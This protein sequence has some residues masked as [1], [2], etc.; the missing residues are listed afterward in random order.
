M[1]CCDLDR[2]IGGL[3]VF[4][5]AAKRQND[6]ERQR[7]CHC[8]QDDDGNYQFV[9]SVSTAHLLALLPLLLATNLLLEA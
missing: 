4:R 3:L 8:T 9:L 7:H 5:T 1:G 6:A 2:L